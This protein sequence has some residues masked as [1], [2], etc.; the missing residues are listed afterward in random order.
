MPTLRRLPRLAL[1]QPRLVLGALTGRCESGLR[2]QSTRCRCCCVRSAAG[3]LLAHV[4]STG[5]VVGI[6]QST[7]AKKHESQKEGNRMSKKPAVL[8]AGLVA[9]KG[10][11]SPAADMP[12][13]AAEPA[14]TPER[15]EKG[16]GEALLPLNFRVGASFRREFKTY[17]AAHDLKLNE[18]L[19]RCFAAYRQQNGE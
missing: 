14:S 17:A 16:R 18:L 8:S 3:Y 19:R 11:A 12:S 4:K 15:A 7:L 2:L 1:G 9:V 13:R 10:A 5:R 6:R